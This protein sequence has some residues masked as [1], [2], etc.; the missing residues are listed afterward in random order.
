[1]DSPPENGPDGILPIVYAELRRLAASYLSRE[2][3]GHTL[4]ASA[5]VNEAYLKL[6]D[7]NRVEWKNRAHFFGVSAQ[8]MRHILVDIARLMTSAEMGL[9]D[10]AA[11]TA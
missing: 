7:I 5:L 8:M 2:R 11:Q 6:V 3:Q 4:Q 1:M 9:V 10:A